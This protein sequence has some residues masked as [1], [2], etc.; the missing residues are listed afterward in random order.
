[1]A[2]GTAALSPAQAAQFDAALESLDDAIAAA[3]PARWR[4]D[5][6]QAEEP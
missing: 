3:L 5:P 6:A 2:K 4:S 1:V